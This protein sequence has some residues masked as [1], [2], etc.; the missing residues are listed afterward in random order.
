M[1]CHNSSNSSMYR[2]ESSEAYWSCSSKGEGNYIS[3]HGGYH[4]IPPK[5]KLFAL[6]TEISLALEDANIP[7]KYRHHEVGGAG[8]CQIETPLLGLIRSAD[9]SMMVKYFTK[10][11]AANNNK[12][13]TFLPKPLFGESGSGMHFHQLLFKSN[14]N[15]FYDISDKYRLSQSA[16]YYIGGLL[17]HAPSVMAFTDPT[18]NSYRRLVPGFEAPINCFFP[19]GNRSA[20]IRIPKYA[21]QPVF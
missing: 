6:R 21:T 14:I 16:Y 9:A 10:M 3:P 17:K 18:T 7:I 19:S 11:I 2:F 8:Q 12:T 20:A 13:V 4:V 5:D 1:E 15:I